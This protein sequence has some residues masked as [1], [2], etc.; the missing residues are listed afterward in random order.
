MDDCWQQMKCGVSAGARIELPQ[1]GGKMR[2]KQ[3]L[4]VSKFD[5]HTHSRNT[6]YLLRAQSNMQN[7]HFRFYFSE[8]K[9]RVLFPLYFLCVC[10]CVFKLFQAALV[11]FVRF[12]FIWSPYSIEMHC[13]KEHKK[14]HARAM[15]NSLP[16]KWQTAKM[17]KKRR[18]NWERNLNRITFAK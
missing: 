13:N 10:V 9:L 14:R 8:P 16:S 2:R 7:M 11:L 15:K 17:A 18:M 6:P 3:K 4:R 1:D 12:F 5:F